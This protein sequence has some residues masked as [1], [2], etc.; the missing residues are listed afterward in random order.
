LSFFS[1]L[2]EISHVIYYL[3]NGEGGSFLS[4]HMSMSMKT[5]EFSKPTYSEWQEE[6]VKALKGKPFESLFTKTIENITLEPLYTQEQLIEKYG[7]QLEKQI[8]T[9]RSSTSKERFTTAQQIVGQTAESFIDNLEQSIARGNELLVIDNRIGFEWT[10]ETLQ[11]VADFMTEY[12]F[13]LIVQSKED[14]ILRTF[15]LIDTAKRSSVEGFIVANEAIT[16][17]NFPQVRTVSAN[18]LPFHYEGASAVQELAIALAQAA[19]QIGDKS[20]EQ[21]EK[22]F[23]VNFAIDTQFFMEIA[24]IRAFKVL[25]KAFSQA[26]G[27]DYSNVPVLAETSL[28][29]FSKLDVY[30]N[31][32]RT[33]NA[34]L[35]AAIGGVD[36]FTIHPH[37]IL[38]E[39][40]EQSVRI[41]R[42]ISLV[43]KEESHVL[44]VIDPAGGSYFVESLT[45]DLVKEAWALFLQIEEAGGLTAYKAELTE[46]IE[47]VQATR[48]KQ[49]A[50]RKQSLIGTNIYAN[51]KDV[52]PSVENKNV[53]SL[54][55]LAKPFEELRTQ[56]AT[57]HANIAILTFG[58]L[59]NY[60]PRADFVAGVLAVAGVEPTVTE[61][62]T[63]VEEAKAYLQT[64]NATY[65]I[66][67]ATDDDTKMLIPSLLEG[68]PANITLDAA[69]KYKDDAEAWLAAGLNGFVFAG[70]NIVEKLQQ[71]A[72]TVKGA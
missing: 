17:A 36:V 65:V 27:V 69:G 3:E 59:K 9:I 20:F 60:K 24:K 44:N 22:T 31:L 14:A 13:K 38:T 62:F 55:R 25:W 28:R 10:E 21:F 37:D 51:P 23:F 33:G 50:T 53:A 5:I 66:V 72:A 45:A 8:T 67:A 32:L 56:F 39:V 7:E 35:S 2:S 54:Q 19:E 49:V 4:D 48:V 6:A 18:T 29:S 40:S 47:E 70:Q 12:P 43:T 71:I 61:G 58:E 16:L 42:N 11:K 68:K 15:D 1:L 46:A 52:I 64:T 30:V 34:S 63:T 57:L 26:Y 41:A